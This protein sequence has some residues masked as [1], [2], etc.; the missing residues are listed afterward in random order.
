MRIATGDLP[1]PPAFLIGQVGDQRIAFH[2]TAGSFYLNNE[3]INGDINANTGNIINNNQGNQ[4]LPTQAMP[5][6]TTQS[7]SISSDP[8]AMGASQFRGAEPG[9]EG[10]CIDSRV[11]AGPDHKTCC[12]PEASNQANKVLA[13][14]Y[15]GNIGNE[16]GLINESPQ[17]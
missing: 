2:G 1:R 4:E 14:Q 3:H 12:G 8:A 6:E 17:I 9:T 7:T 11:L 10:V 5:G 16:C 13:T 15:A